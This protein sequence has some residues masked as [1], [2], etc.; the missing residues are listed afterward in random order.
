[1]PSVSTQHMKLWFKTPIWLQK[2]RLSGKFGAQ[3]GHDGYE[4]WKPKKIALVEMNRVNPIANS[5]MTIPS[6][7]VS[8]CATPKNLPEIQNPVF[9]VFVC[10][11]CT[12]CLFKLHIWLVIITV[13][14]TVKFHHDPCIVTKQKKPGRF[15]AASRNRFGLVC[16]LVRDYG[17]GGWSMV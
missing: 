12:I 3:I 5:I 10:C 8:F 15:Y 14:Y 1:M 17:V 2:Y 13:E 9:F 7:F 16:F 4:L 11:K 6:W